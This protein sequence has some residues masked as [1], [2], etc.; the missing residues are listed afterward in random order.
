MTRLRTVLDGIATEAPAVDLADRVIAGHRRRRRA[1]LAFAAVATA[2]VTGAGAITGAGLLPAGH[3]DDAATTTARA[4]QGPGSIPDLPARGVGPLGYAYLSFC[5][6]EGPK[7]ADCRDHQWRVITRAGEAYHL[8][9]ALGMYG[10][11]NWAP[12]AMSRD[13]RMLAYY[14]SEAQTFKVRDLAAGTELTAPVT[15]KETELAGSPSLVLS[16]DGRTLAFVPDPGTWP[17]LLPGLLIDLRASTA[18]RLPGGW[19]PTSIE[20]GQ[21]TMVALQPAARV[22]VGGG[23]PV[24][25]GAGYKRFSALAPDGRSMAA[26]RLGRDDRLERTLTVLDA[27]TGAETRKVAIRG[28][29]G[30]P[31]LLTL[32]TWLNPGEVTLAALPT[33]DAH[34]N[35]QAIYAVNVET[36]QTRSLGVYPGQ[37]P[38][39]LVVPGAA[40]AR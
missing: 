17:G 36:G 30:K 27:T 14:S 21:V 33:D 31:Y 9:Q 15:V 29:A 4:T 34:E 5:K 23:T 18:R 7:P 8:P 24:T 35:R 12:L 1:R 13:G 38:V 19:R 37:S 25:V 11:G 10:A 22:W 2:A 32:G 26:L 3:G 20:G 39:H 28:L 16:D 40:V 6:V